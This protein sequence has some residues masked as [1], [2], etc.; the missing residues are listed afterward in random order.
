MDQIGIPG[1]E[2][3]SHE[4]ALLLRRLCEEADEPALF[5]PSLCQRRAAGRIAALLDDLRLRALP[6]HT[7]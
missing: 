6:P 5:D 4:Q 1:E 7:D 3:M 2:L